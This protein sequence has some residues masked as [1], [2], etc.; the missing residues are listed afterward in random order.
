[1][2]IRVTELMSDWTRG[3]CFNCYEKDAV[4]AAYGVVEDV[5]NRQTAC[6]ARADERWDLFRAQWLLLVES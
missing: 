5:R 3:T 6:R 1:M 4:V 2:K